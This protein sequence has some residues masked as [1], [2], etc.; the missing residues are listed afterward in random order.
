[1]KKTQIDMVR[2][3][4]EYSG[5]P[6]GNKPKCIEPNRGYERQGYLYEELDEFMDAT[7]VNNLDD[8]IDALADLDYFLK[9]TLVEMGVP[10]ECYEEFFAEVHR[11]N[12]TKFCE[13][14]EDAQTSVELYKGGMHPQ[15]VGKEFPNASYRQQGERWIVFDGKSQ[16][17]LKSYMTE[18]PNTKPILEKYMK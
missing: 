5:H 9:G 3:F 2:E 4:H 13:T 1:M 17:I 10:A 14:K 12:M 6:V 7:H 11:A 15:A 16:K 8:A 18:K